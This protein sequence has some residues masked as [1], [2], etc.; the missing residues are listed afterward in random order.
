MSVERLNSVVKSVIGRRRFSCRCER[1]GLNFLT[2]CVHAAQMVRLLF[3]PVVE[4]PEN[5]CRMNRVFSI[6]LLLLVMA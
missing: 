4:P 5:S 1:F 6:F 2:N 3:A